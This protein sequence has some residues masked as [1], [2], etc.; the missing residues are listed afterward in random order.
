VE[1]EE[2]KA[3][4]DEWDNRDIP[5]PLKVLDSPF[6]EI[7]S[8]VVDYVKSVRRGSP[9]DVVMVYI[10][11]YVVGRWY[12]QLL[13]NQTALRLKSRLFFTAGVMVTSVPW[14][15]RSS[16]GA[17][18][19]LQGTQTRFP[20]PDVPRE[21]GAEPLAGIGMDGTDSERHGQ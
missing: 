1:P 8:S 11:E 18:E 15:L 17:E 4:Q 2:T 9:R 12:E 6:R 20:G 21:A 16:E 13:H 19:R 5:V 3:L 10:P 7:T 14:Q